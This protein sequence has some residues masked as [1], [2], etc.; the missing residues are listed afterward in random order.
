MDEKT[1][2]PSMPS[3]ETTQTIGTMKFVVVSQ[4]Q[5]NGSTIEEKI[6]RLLEREAQEKT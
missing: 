6:K 3:E 1:I 4:F 2:I 5:D